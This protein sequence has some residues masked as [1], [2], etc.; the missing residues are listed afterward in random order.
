MHDIPPRGTP[1]I[2]HEAA[3]TNTS[4]RSDF[5]RVIAHGCRTHAIQSATRGIENWLRYETMHV[6]NTPGSPPPHRCIIAYAVRCR[7]RTTTGSCLRPSHSL[8]Q[9]VCHA[10]PHYMN[11]SC[12]CVRSRTCTRDL[13]LKSL[14]D[15]RAHAQLSDRWRDHHETF[16][17]E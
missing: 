17:G 8:P 13:I 2:I 6:C 1:C 5:W 15:L 4:D 3:H 12:V 9:R 16:D 14:S 7:S 11:M 10:R